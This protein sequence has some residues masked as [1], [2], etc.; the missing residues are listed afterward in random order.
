MIDSSCLHRCCIFTGDFK[1]K[2]LGNGAGKSTLRL[3]MQ[4]ISKM[5]MTHYST[6]IKYNTTSMVKACYLVYMIPGYSDRV[7]SRIK[8]FRSLIE[9]DVSSDSVYY[10]TGSDGA[11]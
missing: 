7:L 9:G 2:L 8:I 1:T 11:E 4:F 10:S 5:S 3:G 6:E